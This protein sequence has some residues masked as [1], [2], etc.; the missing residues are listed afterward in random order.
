MSDSNASAKKSVKQFNKL[1]YSLV[2]EIKNID[3]KRDLT[4]ERKT[5]FSVKVTVFTKQVNYS[6]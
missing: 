5:D 6:R 4:C 2:A 3:K 1:H